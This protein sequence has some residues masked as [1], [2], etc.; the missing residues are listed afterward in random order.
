[1]ERYLQIGKENL[2][3]NL[4][5]P[6]IVAAVMLMF[7]PLVMGV[8]NLDAMQSAQVLEYYVAL[9]GMVLLPPIF[10]PEQNKDIRDL[11]SSKHTKIQW[12]YGVRVVQAMVILAV[13]L[14]IY[15][16]LLKSGGCTFEGIKFYLG[17]LAEMLFLGGIGIL[18]Y[19][20][21]DQ[22]VIGYM[23]PMVYYLAAF[24]SGKKWMG[25]WY[26]FSMVMG[27][28]TEKWCLGIAGIF[29]IAFGIYWRARRK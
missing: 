17:T 28:Y 15:I 2:K 16:L 7:S 22:V 26:P 10:L 12:I 25:Y 29:C 3:F 13:F 27:S 6:I 8:K 9:I 5:L 24:G 21:S 1:M 23:A 11:I 20:L 18:A 19:S 4:P 14:G